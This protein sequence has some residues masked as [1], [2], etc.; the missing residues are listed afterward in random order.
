MRCTS[1]VVVRAG[2][3]GG[4]N[5][6]MSERRGAGPPAARAGIASARGQAR[7]FTLAELLVVISII[8]LLV[9]MLLP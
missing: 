5:P 4:R 2:P 9:S 1:A 8:A 7:G 6:A 3:G